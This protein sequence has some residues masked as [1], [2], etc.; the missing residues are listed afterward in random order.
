MG[1][2]IFLIENIKVVA[3][4][5]LKKRMANTC[6]FSIIVGKLS[7]QKEISLIVLFLIDEGFE[8]GLYS[9]I[10]S[11]SLAINFKVDSNSEPLLD[12]KKIA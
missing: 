2:N 8:V 12:S 10:L 9:T 11:F 7:H 6:I 4:V 1:V 3:K 5:E